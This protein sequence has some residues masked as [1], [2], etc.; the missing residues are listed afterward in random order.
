MKLT[1]RPNLTP[2]EKNWI[3]ENAPEK[4]I[5]QMAKET[6]LN[7][8]MIRTFCTTENIDYIRTKNWSRAEKK[9]VVD[10]GYFRVD[11]YTCWITGL[12]LSS[13]NAQ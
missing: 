8:Q 10:N 13:Q 1:R 6:K 12:K 9:E 2:E 7:G 5:K 3:R 11:A 4:T